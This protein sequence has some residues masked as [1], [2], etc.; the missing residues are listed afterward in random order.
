MMYIIL[1]E[2]TYFTLLSTTSNSTKRPRSR[3]KMWCLMKSWWSAL[4]W[5]PTLRGVRHP[6]VWREEGTAARVRSFPP[7]ASCSGRL[8]MT[9]ASYSGNDVGLDEL[10][11]RFWFFGLW[12]K[13]FTAATS[14]HSMNKMISSLAT[15]L[16]KYNKPL[17]R[18]RRNGN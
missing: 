4:R 12:T 8:I 9:S 11:Y 15:T 5:L 17:H 6:C 18:Y 14:P 3:K 13:W 2:L 7:N 16:L 10:N 1:Q